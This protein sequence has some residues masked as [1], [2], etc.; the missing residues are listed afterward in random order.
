MSNIIRI[1]QSKKPAIDVV[2]DSLNLMKLNSKNM[3]PN[4]KLSMLGQISN[5][6]VTES[7]K[8]GKEAV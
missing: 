1:K 3:S 7:S 4:Q 8:N 2:A 6:K 5:I